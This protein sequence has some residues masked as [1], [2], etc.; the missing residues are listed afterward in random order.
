MMYRSEI[1]NTIVLFLLCLLAAIPASAQDNNL[2]TAQG[3][4]SKVALAAETV[5]LSTDRS[6]YLS[7]EMIYVSSAILE[8]DN[9]SLSGLS[10]IIRLELIGH[11]GKTGIRN[12]LYAEDGRAAGT[13]KIP[14]NLPTGCKE[15]RVRVSWTDAGGGARSTVLVCTKER[16]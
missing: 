6:I 3:N 4:K 8:L 10:K 5:L 13:I 7:G 14:G 12:E 16:I 9:Y 1:K 15:I 2:A 11:D